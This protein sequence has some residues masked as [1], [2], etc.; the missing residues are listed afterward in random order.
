VG[1]DVTEEQA[2]AAGMD[3]YIPKP[4][5]LASLEQALARWVRIR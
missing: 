1:G 5:T 2:Q 4:I 3:D